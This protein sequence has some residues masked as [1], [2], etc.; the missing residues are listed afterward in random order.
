VSFPLLPCL[1]RSLRLPPF[2]LRCVR[3]ASFLFRVSSCSTCSCFRAC[4]LLSRCHVAAVCPRVVV[5]WPPVFFC[6]CTSHPFRIVAFTCA[7]R[8]LLRGHFSAVCLRVGLFVRVAFVL[9]LRVS[10][11]PHIVF[12][13]P[14]RCRV[15]VLLCASRVCVRPRRC[16]T[17]TFAVLCM[18]LLHVFS[19]SSRSCRLNRTVQVRAVHGSSRVR[20]YSGTWKS[21]Y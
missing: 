16:F 12:V 20:L 8:L 18:S 13:C 21:M 9:L 19:C 1:A 4:T 2:L 15:V 5:C 7:A 3:S 10:L 17:P 14:R 6:V 11:C